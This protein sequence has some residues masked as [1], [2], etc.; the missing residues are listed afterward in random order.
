MNGAQT[1]DSY[2]IAA[3]FFNAIGTYK[4]SA[5]LAQECREKAECARKNEIYSGI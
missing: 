1:E 4:D 2:L 3:G 5:A